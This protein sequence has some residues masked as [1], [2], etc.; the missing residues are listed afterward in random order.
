MIQPIFI[1]KKQ[2]K[3]KQFD[4]E[5]LRAEGIKLIQQL[6]GEYWTD[7]NTHDPGVTIL[8]QLCFAISELAYRTDFN[9]EDLLFREGK[10][11]HSFFRPDQ[12]LP[13][14]ALTINDYRKLLFDSVFEIKN[15][16]LQPIDNNKNSLNGLYSILLDI[17]EGITSKSARN[18]V[19]SKAKKVF[20]NNRNLCEDIEEIQILEHLPV[21][22]H[23][24]IEL[25]GTES[26]EKVMGEL[27][28]RVDE[29]LCPQMKFYSLQEL[30]EEGF[31]L[32]EIF[33]GPL[34]KHGFIK[35]NELPPKTDKIMI[36]ELM[37][38]IMQVE[39]VNSVKNLFIEADGQYHYNQLDIPFGMLARLETDLES[40]EDELPIELTKGRVSYAHIEKQK[41]ARNLNELR[42]ANKRVYR[43]SEETIDVPEG[44]KVDTNSYYSIQ[45]HFPQ[46]YGLGID[47]ISSYASPERKAQVM[48]LKGYLMLFEQIL[49]NYLA[50]L[51]G[52]G[53][54]L[55]FKNTEQKTYFYKTLDEVPYADKLYKTINE[56][57]DPVS[58]RQQVIPSN[59]LEGLKSLTEV[60]DDYVD[61]RGRFLDYLLALHGESF[62]EVG[63][64][65]FKYYFPEKTDDFLLKNKTRL[66][67]FIPFIN[68]NRNR[69][70][71]YEQDFSNEGNVAGLEV[72]L[73]VLLGLNF[74]SINDSIISDNI[75]LID[76]FK[77]QKLSITEKVKKPGKPK[78]AIDKKYFEDNF[79]YIDLEELGENEVD[80]NTF[81][82]LNIFSE[83][84]IDE[85]FLREGLTLENYQV[86]PDNHNEGKFIAAF[87]S[88]NSS[89]PIALGSFESEEEASNVVITL[90]DLLKEMN[91][92]C[93]GLHLIEHILLRPDVNDR[94]FGIYILD[95]NGNRLL[96][97][98]QCFTFSER[99]AMVKKLKPFIT[100][101]EYYSVETTSTKDF[102]IQFNVDDQN[103]NF[104]SVKPDISVEKTHEIKE[105]LYRFMSDEDDIVPFENKIDFFIQND[106]NGPL[107]PEDFFEYRITM[108]FPSWT[109][110]FNDPE[111]RSVVEETVRINQPANIDTRLFWFSITQ[112]KK[113][114]KLYKNWVIGL[115]ENDKTAL[116]EYSKELILI[117]L[118][119]N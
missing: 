46:V 96:R 76:H 67:E 5:A 98:K 53:Q 105:K 92:K 111:F 109:A 32:N 1:E 91:L 11:E 10:K 50:Q 6:A 56:G 19:L 31:T 118:G 49:V 25:S 20:L 119:E 2:R 101:E 36:S 115:K 38:V 12:V 79:D 29:Y 16:W 85:E 59:Y 26:A 23:A 24:E 65:S 90:I 13:C 77:N 66:L 88:P 34:L 14:N 52:V 47:G 81:K 27:L 95:E 82:S 28:Y 87:S 103:I 45:N 60:T 74:Y 99:L 83:G 102:E 8:E 54:L 94:K 113:F 64:Q 18:N 37:K 44:K 70:V 35:T 4:Y 68:K 73:S 40:F 78:G 93:E 86:G 75:S 39:G 41:V 51:S 17:D 72:K 43:L 112:M 89:Y 104:V 57:I 58:F 22:L 97:S 21:V 42:S 33:E 84:K 61:R 100:G 110:R 48:Q 3:E 7:F 15:V 116:D 80:E 30:I 69:G 62:P 108:I 71:D 106:E 63:T 55:S 117:L 107:I 9:I 114:E